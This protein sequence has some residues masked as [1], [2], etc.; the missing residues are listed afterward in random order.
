MVVHQHARY[1][2][3]DRP[4]TVMA[5]ACSALPESMLPIAVVASLNPPSLHTVLTLRPRRSR[6]TQQQHRKSGSGESQLGRS[7]AARGA[8]PLPSDWH[9]CL[10]ASLVA[11]PRAP[12]WARMQEE[13][14]DRYGE[15]PRE[16]SCRTSESPMA[17]PSRDGGHGWPGALPSTGRQCRSRSHMRTTCWWSR[18][19]CAGPWFAWASWHASRSTAC[20]VC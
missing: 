8:A 5:A 16:A 12:T 19:A 20:A 7:P 17:C 15:G 2:T 4:R 13:P 18:R 14:V 11:W 1:T 3:L 9:A 10:P 6:R